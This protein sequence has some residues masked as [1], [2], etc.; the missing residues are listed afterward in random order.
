MFGYVIIDKPNILIKDYATYKAYYCGMC[1][2][3]AKRSGEIMRLTLNYD[4]VLL[5]LL[6]HNYEKKDPEFKQGHC[7][8]HWS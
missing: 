6:A 3:L 2:S 1:K 7:P 5:S 4:I 8:I